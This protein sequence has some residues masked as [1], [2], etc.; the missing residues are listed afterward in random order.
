MQLVAPR[1]MPK[2]QPREARARGAVVSVLSGKGGVGKTVISTNLALALA[3]RAGEVLLVDCDLS[4]GQSHLVLGVCPSGGLAQVVRGHKRL[5]DIVLKAADGLLLAPGGPSG[6][7]VTDLRGREVRAILG[8][9]VTAAPEARAILFDGGSGRAP[10][11]ADFVKA[12]DVAI[13]LTSPEPTA[14]RATVALLESLLSEC[15][16]SEPCMVVNMASD[17]REARA[18]FA[19]IADALLPV[20]S[21][22]PG[23]L[24]WIPSDP[25]V[26]RSLR[27]YRPFLTDAPESR[28]AAGVKDLA[29]ALAP[30]L[31]SRGD[32]GNGENV[33]AA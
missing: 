18:T 31:G 1:P 30:R 8:E 17:E 25:Q 21:A 10:A 9:A 3:A 4:A 7:Y 11:A 29:A 14:V 19:K 16:A 13:V 23:L 20:F 33:Q 12:A 15:P 27:K 22:G 6:E 26:A 5:G 24:G 32:L 28:A 2:S